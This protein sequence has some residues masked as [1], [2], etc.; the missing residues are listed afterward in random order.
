MI[1][2]NNII[3]FK[4]K[5]S[6]M[7]NPADRLIFLEDLY[8]RKYTYFYPTI[9]DLSIVFN[10]DS[11]YI[12]IALK[13]LNLYNTKQCNTCLNWLDYSKFN[14]VGKNGNRFH[15]DCIECS[16]EKMKPVSQ[17]HYFEN[18]PEIRKRAN[19]TQNERYANDYAFKLKKRLLN[20]IYT[21]L[22]RNQND[23]ITKLL[24]FT[25]TELELHLASHFDANMNWSNYGS[26]W[27]IDH[28]RPITS[29]DIVDENSDDFK[30]C[31]SLDN[32]RP[33]ENSENFKKNNKYVAGT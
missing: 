32:L 11:S 3:S 2:K 5:L 21:Y 13:Q 15:A 7:D 23:S 31:W 4:N 12:I 16:K 27:S 18:K 17:Q 1:S 29:F 33:L 22:K 28:I 9:E 6:I 24:P 14:T 8:K 10:C 30:L 26:Y 19:K 20:G 25:M